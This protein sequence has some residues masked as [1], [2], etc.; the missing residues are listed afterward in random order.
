MAEPLAT[1]L[2]TELAG[3]A[4]IVKV[5]VGVVVALATAVVKKFAPPATKLPELNEVTVAA[6]AQPVELPLARMPCANC[7]AGQGMGNDAN[8]VAVDALPVV[9][10]FSVGMKVEGIV[11]AA[12]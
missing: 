1:L 9:F 6:A 3:A 10:W 4:L 12:L 11:F 5:C 7:P 8:C 2:N